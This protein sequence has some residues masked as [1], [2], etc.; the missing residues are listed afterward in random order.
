MMI[1]GA[2]V[3]LAGGSAAAMGAGAAA[4]SAHYGGLNPVDI[5]FSTGALKN[6]RECL[7]G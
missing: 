2:T 6:L 1:G 4:T 5:F 3:K 7:G